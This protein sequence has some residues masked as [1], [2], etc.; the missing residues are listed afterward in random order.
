MHS[1]ASFEKFKGIRHKAFGTLFPVIV[2]HKILAWKMTQ[3]SST[4]EL[5]K[6]NQPPVRN[7]RNQYKIG[8]AELT[9]FDTMPTKEVK[10]NYHSFADIFANT[11]FYEI[12]G[13]HKLK[14]KAFAFLTNID[15]FKE[16]HFC[17]KQIPTAL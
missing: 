16:T 11:E 13:L 8:N 15:L 4:H 12:D 6:P 1:V 7:Y 14:L 17:Y 3:F 5:G 10:Y 9:W 2:L